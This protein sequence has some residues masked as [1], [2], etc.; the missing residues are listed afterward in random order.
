MMK[1]LNM[2]NT[3]I[4]ASKKLASIKEHMY[5]MEKQANLG[6]R[7]A[8]A[9]RGL[10]NLFTREVTDIASGGMKRKLK[11]WAYPLAIGAAAGGTAAVTAPFV[12]GAGK[13]MDYLW[14]QV[15]MVGRAKAYRN[16]LVEYGPELSSVAYEYGSPDNPIPEKRIRGLFNALY[17]VA[18][19]IAKEPTLASAQMSS[20]IKDMA[21]SGGDETRHL[22]EGGMTPFEGAV[23]VQRTLPR[24]RLP[25]EYISDAGRLA[26]MT[27]K[28]SPLLGGAQDPTARDHQ[29]RQQIA[30]QQYGL[31]ED[32]AGAALRRDAGPGLDI[33]EAQQ[34]ALQRARSVMETPPDMRDM[35]PGDQK[36]ALQASRNRNLDAIRRREEALSGRSPGLFPLSHHKGR[37]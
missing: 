12:F 11:P 33:Y 30:E 16:M 4:K 2:L 10:R 25:S 18:P 6:S 23:N 19:E 35:S 9:G 26:E 13:G 22:L 3:E 7:L 32:A 24:D 15:N 31:K 17:K 1:Q 5:S 21:L 8:G 14:G 36:A 28:Y 34:L 29:L 37:G 20:L 27:R